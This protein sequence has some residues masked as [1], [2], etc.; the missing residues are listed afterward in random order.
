MVHECLAQNDRILGVA[1]AQLNANNISVT[2]PMAQ[3]NRS[4]RKGIAGLLRQTISS[5]Q[6]AQNISDINALTNVT[7]NL[8]SGDRLG[9]IGSNGAGK[10]TLL[11]TLGGIY[12]PNQGNV[13]AKGSIQALLTLGSWL[14]PEET[15]RQNIEFFCNYRCLSASQSKK[16]SEDVEEFSELGE[17]LNY[18]LRTYSTGMQTRLGFSL[19]TALAPEI[20]LIDEIIGAGDARFF[21][22]AETRMRDMAHNTEILVLASHSNALIESWCNKVAWMESG[23]VREI[24]EPAKIIADYQAWVG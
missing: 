18:P 1:V 14:D 11:K 23:R 24:G 22:K 21:K 7:L 12:F 5:D 15:G 13:V 17:F 2:F 10:S 20:L 3:N 19:A 8:R 9:L 16:V 4:L 6:A